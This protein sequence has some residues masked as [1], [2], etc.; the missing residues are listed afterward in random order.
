SR[1]CLLHQIRRC[2]APCV[3]LI[4]TASY[5]DDVRNAELFLL[6]RDDEVLDKLDRQMQVAAENLAFETAAAYRDQIRA[7]RGVRQTQFVSRERAR[8]VGLV[9]RA[10]AA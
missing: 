3:G 9:P 10:A 2:S 8:A 1:P 7:L 6:G 5:A 4:D